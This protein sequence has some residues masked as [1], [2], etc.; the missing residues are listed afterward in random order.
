MDSAANDGHEAYVWVIS[1]CDEDRNRCVVGVWWQAAVV[2]LSVLRWLFSGIV[3]LHGIGKYL[4][5]HRSYVYS[6]NTLYL[7][8]YAEV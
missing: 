2:G 4:S 8:A 1:N 3:M 6:S 5:Y 7:T